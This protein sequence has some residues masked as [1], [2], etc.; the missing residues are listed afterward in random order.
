MNEK[1]RD[2]VILSV[3]VY[4]GDVTCF[5]LVKIGNRFSFR[6]QMI[7]MNTIKDL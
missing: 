5:V 3:H 7:Y 4:M 6:Y 1:Q 2:S